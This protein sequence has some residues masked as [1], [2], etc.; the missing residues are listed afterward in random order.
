M[1]EIHL[2]GQSEKVAAENSFNLS[3]P[4]LYHQMRTV[5]ALKIVPL[6]MNAYNTG[7]GKTYASLLHLFTMTGKPRDNVLFIAP[8][9]ELLH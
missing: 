9:N 2:T 8:T 6:V 4:P 5:E 7:T 3:Q 1:I